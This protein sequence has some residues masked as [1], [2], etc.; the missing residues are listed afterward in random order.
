MIK[1]F[2]YD[3]SEYQLLQNELNKLSEKGYTTD[4]LSHITHFKKIKEPVFYLVDIYTT[5]DNKDINSFKNY[6][7]Y[8]L[9]ND[10]EL[11]S[12]FNNLLVF[13]GNKKI[14]PRTNFKAIA[15]GEKSRKLFYFLLSLVLLFLILMFIM[16]PLQPYHLLTNGNILFY[17]SIILIPFTLVYRTFLCWSGTYQLSKSIENKKELKIKFNNI[18]YQ[19]SNVLPILIMLCLLISPLFD[20]LN[21]KPIKEIPS[22]IYTLKDF[23]IHNESTYSIYSKTS[24]IVPLSYEYVETTKDNKYSIIVQSYQLYNKNSVNI[25]LED[26]INNPDILYMDTF[27]EI[28]SKEY[29]GYYKNKA[30]IKIIIEENTLTLINTSFEIK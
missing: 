13:K 5:N 23:N 24:L 6:M 7:K 20:I 2:H 26:F 3:I 10:Y 25:M 12:T 4:K 8:Y 1:L 15:Q 11:I 21:T 14:K 19:I 30:Y 17:I 9:E 18:Y 27:K 28:S 16:V 22:H 29:I